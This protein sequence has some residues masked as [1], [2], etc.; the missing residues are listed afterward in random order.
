LVSTT[1]PAARGAFAAAVFLFVAASA[2]AQEKAGR[3]HTDPA[4]SDIAAPAASEKPSPEAPPK[5]EAAADKAPATGS[6]AARAEFEKLPKAAWEV[7][8]R[9]DADGKRMA[10]VMT[11]V[12]TI[13]QTNDFLM[14]VEIVPPGVNGNAN[15]GI[16]LT[17]PHGV[18]IPPGITIRVDDGQTFRVPFQLSDSAG[19]Y[20]TQPLGADIIKAMKAGQML[21]VGLVLADGSKREIPAS[22]AGFTLAYDKILD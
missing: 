1:G 7:S 10:C 19:L 12:L 6:G 9:P 20:T 15:A 3:V 16:R 8:C 5:G 14:R 22:L 17:L 2:G 4:A 18:L 21:T 13:A 11:Q